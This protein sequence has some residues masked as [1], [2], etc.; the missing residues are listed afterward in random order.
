[1]FLVLPKNMNLSLCDHACVNPYSSLVFSNILILFAD[2][3]S[4]T[5]IHFPFKAFLFLCIIFLVL[6]L[7]YFTIIGRRSSFLDFLGFTSLC[8]V[9]LSSCLIFW[10]MYTSV[11]IHRIGNSPVYSPS[12]SLFPW[13]KCHN[14][15]QNIWD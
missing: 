6:C 3:H 10:L 4:V 12:I 11:I 14:N 8:H 9:S 13:I 15:S 1:M 7:T 5:L 2:K